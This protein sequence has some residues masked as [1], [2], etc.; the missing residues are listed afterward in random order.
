MDDYVITNGIF[1]IGRDKN[2][3]IVSNITN[4]NKAEIMSYEKATKILKNNLKSI[5]KQWQIEAATV[6]NKIDEYCVQIILED[7][8]IMNSISE[9][10]NFDWSECTKNIE[11]FTYNIYEYKNL[12]FKNLKRIDL[13]LSDIRH[14]ISNNKPNK[15]IQN[16]IYK[17]EY[18]REVMRKKIKTLI[19]YLNVIIDFL[20]GRCERIELEERIE[21]AKDKPFKGRTEV[22]NELIRIIA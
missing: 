13:E 6:K 5:N 3:N 17:M 8:T 11:P 9:I 15:K 18:E 20:E 2:G 19:R 1:Y 21:E 12:L 16:E 22:Y 10:E 14:I 4:I 7:K